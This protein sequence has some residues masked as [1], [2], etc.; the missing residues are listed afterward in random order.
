MDINNQL[1]LPEYIKKISPYQ[2]GKPIN[3]LAREFG[4]ESASIVKLASNENSLGVSE[5]VVSALSKAKDIIYRYP[6][7]NGFDLKL[8][9]SEKYSIPVESIVLGNGSNDILELIAMTFL[10]GNSSAIYSEYSFAVYK[11]A[12]QARGASH[13][14]VP[15]SNYGHDLNLFYKSITDNS[16]LIFIAN[17][18]NPT[19]T[20]IKKSDL[21][22]FL[23]SVYNN[24]GSKLIVVLDEAYTEY[25]DE[26]DK[27]N[28]FSLIEKYPNLIV[29]RTFSKAYGLAGLRV[30]FSVSNPN[31]ANFINRVRQPFNVNC[32]AQ[33]AAIEALK[34]Q[35]FLD[36]SCYLNKK[37]KERFYNFFDSLGFKYIPSFGNFILVNVGDSNK[38]NFELLKRGIIVRPVD[39][40][41]L[42]GWLRISI[43]NSLENSLF[44]D[45]L[46]DIVR[47]I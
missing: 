19:G 5:R 47:L 17:P 3:E 11:I 37:E 42:S 22:V 24:Y 26:C 31:I 4:I 32:F 12:T 25:L 13:I 10:D 14:E 20:F 43:G 23:D 9:L 39:N 45:S 29:T 34:D 35:D 36:K 16:R 28:S 38:V 6:D 15:S 33:L 44:F 46:S 7:A 27:F 40:Y 30:G 21:I 8:V 41:N 18:N 1:L 2:S